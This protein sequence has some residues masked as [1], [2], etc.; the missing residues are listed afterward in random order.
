MKRI[1]VAALLCAATQA[2]AQT[3]PTPPADKPDPA[4][5]EVHT[6]PPP[7]VDP[8]DAN[9]PKEKMPDK[10]PKVE[11]PKDVKL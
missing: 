3:P 6:L 11:K 4:K 5:A 7:T 1:I 9:D 8:A 2:F 10:E